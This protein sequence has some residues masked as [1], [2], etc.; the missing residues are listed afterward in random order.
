MLSD[1][2]EVELAHED[3]AIKAPI[4]IVRGQAE[5]VATVFLGYGRSRAG[6][7]GSGAGHNGYALRTQDALDWTDRGTIKKLHAKR[8]LSV[9]H[10]H[11]EMEGRALARRGSFAEF[12]KRPDF[13]KEMGE[14]PPRSLSLYPEQE[15]KGQQWGMSIDLSACTGCNA[16][17]I[18]CQAENNIAVVGPEQVIAERE[19]H[20]IRLDLYAEG[21]EDDPRRIHMPV[22]CQH[23]EN[24]PCELVCPVDA[25]T[26]SPS[27]LNEMVYNRCIGTRYCSHNCPYK[28][29]RFNFLHYNA[30]L[31]SS[32]TLKMLMNPDVTVRSRG[33][34]E[35]CSFCV[36]RINHARIE[37]KKLDRPI[38]DGEI[39]TA[40]EAACPSRAIVFG[41]IN[42]PESRVSRAK[43]EPLAYG[44][45][46]DLNTR[47]RVTY[48]ARIDNP[49]PAITGPDGLGSKGG[50]ALPTRDPRPSK[51]DTHGHE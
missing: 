43:A 10:G 17:T 16:C 13:A 47:P 44:L 33:V 26:H 34:M 38:L 7:W 25:T 42:D 2:D 5:D 19:M 27:G 51:A 28:V 50:A 29:R 15:F 45:L 11:H 39:V 37:A 1:G 23:C 3:R 8:P 4:L 30:P 22:L 41:D 9:T 46:A 21:P 18:A 49:N 24:A 32:E 12:K 48:L 40:C 14:E 6:R 20:W 31:A 35:K 36:Q